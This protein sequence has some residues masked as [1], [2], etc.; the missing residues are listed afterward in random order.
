MAETRE[1]RLR[2]YH[3]RKMAERM[4]VRAA[5]QSQS[6]PQP[7]PQ[8][9]QPPPP[10][11]RVEDNS[12]PPRQHAGK[13]RSLLG[14]R[15]SQHDNDHD[16]DDDRFFGNSPSRQPNVVDEA[17]TTASRTTP[18][19]NGGLSGNIP[20]IRSVVRDFTAA[21]KRDGVVNDHASNRTTNTTQRTKPNHHSNTIIVTE[22]TDDR[23]PPTQSSSSSSRLRSET[24]TIDKAEMKR[25]FAARRRR[26]QIEMVHD[27]SHDASSSRHDDATPQPRAAQRRTVATA[28]SV[29][30][31][32]S[33]HRFAAA[34]FPPSPR[35]RSGKGSSHGHGGGGSSLNSRRA[36]ELYLGRHL[37]GN[38]NSNNSVGVGGNGSHASGGSSHSHG[39]GGDGGS[40][41][42]TRNRG[43]RR[44]Q[45][46]PVGAMGPSRNEE[47][48]AVLS[49]VKE[50]SVR[51]VV[52][53]RHTNDG[54]NGVGASDADAALDNLVHDRRRGEDERNANP[55]KSE[56]TVRF[57]SPL[58]RRRM[59]RPQCS[60]PR[61]RI[62]PKMP[63]Q[64]TVQSDTGEIVKEETMDVDEE[65]VEFMLFVAGLKRE[66][67]GDH[68]ELWAGFQS[69]MGRPADQ[70]TPLYP[71]VA[72]DGGD[73]A[74]TKKK[75]R[76]RMDPQTQAALTLIH[77]ALANNERV[78]SGFMTT[79]SQLVNDKQ[80]KKDR[81]QQQTRIVLEEEKKNVELELRAP[82]LVNSLYGS[83]LR[84]VD[85][86]LSRSAVSP[87]N[88]SMSSKISEKKN[89]SING[90]LEKKDSSLTDS[91]VVSEKDSKQR[92]TWINS[93]KKKKS[94]YLS[95]YASSH[96]NKDK[97]S[98][99]IS[100]SSSNSSSLKPASSLNSSLKLSPINQ[101]RRTSIHTGNNG[102]K[103]KMPSWLEALKKKQKSL[104][105][106]QM[107]SSHEEEAVLDDRPSTLLLS[108]RKR[109][110]F[111][112]PSTPEP[113]TATPWAHVQL[114]STPKKE[115][116]VIV[117]AKTD[118]E[119]KSIHGEGEQVQR[120]ED[121]LPSLFSAGDSINLDE[122]PSSAFAIQEE[123][124]T[125]P[126]LGPQGSKEE[127]DPR[128]VVIVGKSCIVT[129][130]CLSGERKA[131][132]MWW[133][134]RSEIRSL[135]LNVE[136]TG[137]NL[138]IT[139][140]RPSVPLAFPS[141]DVCLS[142]AQ[143]F[144]RGPQKSK[145]PKS[146]VQKPAEQQRSEEQP[147]VSPNNDEDTST[148]TPDEESLIDKYRKFPHRDRPKLK[149]TCL[150]PRGEPEEVEVALSP[151]VSDANAVD[152]TVPEKYRKMIQMGI[153]PDAVRHK[154]T[155]EGV[156]PAIVD[157]VL[158]SN[159]AS[160][161]E[162]KDGNG[163]SLSGEEEFVAS[164][165]RKMLKMKVPTEAVRHKM[166]SEGVDAR[167]IDAVLNGPTEVEDSNVLSEEEEVV[168]SKYR[169]MLKM[170][171]PP[172]AVRHKMTSEGVDPK[173]IES[174]LAPSPEAE[175]ETSSNQLS[176]E[177]EVIAS[178][179]R[180]MLKMKI[181][182]DA[183]KHKMTQD[184]VDLKIVSTIVREAIPEDTEEAPTSS[185][186]KQK[187]KSDVPT[188]TEE[189]EKEA[190]KYRRM[191]KV[192]IPKESIRHAMK[193]DGASD[194][195]VEAVLGKEWLEEKSAPN[196][197]KSKGKTIQLHWT[198]SNLPPELLQQSIFGKADQK[199]RKIATIN[200]EESDIKK[201]E[202]LFQ[203]RD[204]SKAT[205]L[206]AAGTEEVGGDMAKLLD[207]TRANNIAI[208]LKKFND[209]TFRSLAETID[210][211]DPDCKIVGE[212]VQFLP[213]LLPTPKELQAIKKFKGEDDKLVTAELFFRQL[214]SIKRIQ[215][216]VH[217]MKTMHFFEDHVNDIREGFKTLQEVCNQVMN[218]EKLI[219]V[220]EMVLN[221][222]NLMNEGTL[223][224]GVDAFKFESLSKLSQTKSAD[225]KTTVL[226]Y[227]VETFI[228]KGEREALN[229]TSEFPDIQESN[230]LSIGDL[231]S[232]MNSLRKDYNLCKTELTKMKNEQSSK[233]VT[234]SMAKKIH[235]ESEVEDPR[236]ALF[237]A[238]KARGSKEND[239]TAE[240]NDPRQA[241]FAAIKNRK[242]QNEPDED[243][244]SPASSIEYSRGVQRLQDFLN[245][246]KTV[247][248]F[249]DCDQD[250]AIRACKGL[251]VYCGEEG[252]ERAAAPLL[253]ILCDFA[254]SLEN[255]VKKYDARVEAEKR[256]AVKLAKDKGKENQAKPTPRK[257]LKASSFQPHVGV[258]EKVKARSSS[259]HE[260]SLDARQALFD[261]IKDNAS[262]KPKR[263]TVKP[264]RETN[265]TK[266]ALLADIKSGKKPSELKESRIL[267]VN[268]MLSEAPA[269]VKRD[270]LRGVTYENTDDPILKKIYEKESYSPKLSR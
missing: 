7:Q 39:S 38:N 141:A 99:N 166:M 53:G 54:Q 96:P 258:T 250:A 80:V 91:S 86:T 66:V 107:P 155:M 82:S 92:P 198:T 189:E 140:G 110:K 170:R 45:S 15:R 126:L 257:L 204:N 259:K 177:E 63:E 244:K 83:S 219:Q 214:I 64:T 29:D 152:T 160:P 168:A 27:A 33:L 186:P 102:A 248:S 67:A 136:A 6:Q 72:S 231:I 56:K 131:T 125:F 165:Y 179:Y 205:K 95:A 181:P 128:K 9:Q 172:E 73:S 267:L 133:C 121:R 130:N 94:L 150:S 37:G 65:D 184:S 156:D 268:R 46:G 161:H 235:D 215:E 262:N 185:I 124:A 23:P 78:K 30:S 174:V 171:V 192:C 108:P 203:K 62:P 146:L 118:A 13:E 158:D 31:L 206:K 1:S 265:S 12:F 8:R 93:Y 68:T 230:R 104:R 52:E 40:S 263:R 115:N 28:T 103:S 87:S 112:P 195:I 239:G 167:I 264:A 88:T 209:F 202:E 74:D 69:L 81:A 178:K 254:S 61:S 34:P 14:P 11:E 44:E 247:L 70:F 175:I 216:K 208:S 77:K 253:Q 249:A 237:A 143:F 162:M 20:E 269:S 223:N 188:L 157:R 129:A 212:R 117:A 16:D 60:P 111:T 47:G 51:R 90:T 197:S 221:I 238:I 2:S 228:V 225:G 142:F 114:R 137:V 163:S 49:P 135:T 211:L 233:R 84:S 241:L 196:A 246:S 255:A 180:K 134:H 32:T 4:A 147:T 132:V 127:E 229:L 190:S 58:E 245:H 22:P 109:P 97:G 261:A 232:E 79:S 98:P 260:N 183:V 201:L 43:G 105:M 10:L 3:A 17:T 138:A 25:I 191:I 122:L 213:N 187:A 199:K 5:G 24:R 234:R 151:R 159:E 169:K 148:L 41:D 139:N 251:A 173:I 57:V 71:S 164:K 50:E 242:K 207:L 256:K 182:L 36:L 59:T 193:K 113:V 243:D 76:V 217:V 85:V 210:D 218:S 270:F 18:S 119:E 19:T 236:N 144:L 222:G 145:E 224:G 42:S 149:L 200:P 240:N 220:L 101:S 55:S 89:S 35:S 227:I 266:Q 153:P 116:V 123:T 226:D 106:K 120:Q 26:A 75:R 100:P 194:K 154:M 252:G 176:T 21:T 48:E